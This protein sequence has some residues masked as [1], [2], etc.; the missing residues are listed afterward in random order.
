MNDESESRRLVRAP[1]KPDPDLRARKV[2][3]GLSL[4]QDM[5]LEGRSVVEGYEVAWTNSI[6]NNGDVWKTFLVRKEDFWRD[7]RPKAFAV[8]LFAT[9]P[10]S[11]VW[12]ILSVNNMLLMDGFHSEEFLIE[13]AV[14]LTVELKKV[15][16]VERAIQLIPKEGEEFPLRDARDRLPWNKK[17]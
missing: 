17:P 15:D 5:P 3:G 16:E 8:A 6:M 14:R 9:R 4:W 7:I 12:R 13:E 1:I 10:F 2:K 11:G